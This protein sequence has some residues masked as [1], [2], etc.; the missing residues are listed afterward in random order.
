MKVENT[1]II[2]YKDRLID[3]LGADEFDNF[4]KNN[5]KKLHNLTYRYKILD[6]PELLEKYRD[7]YTS[8]EFRVR[9]NNLRK[10]KKL[11]ENNENNAL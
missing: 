8:Y 2:Q 4:F 7:K 3:E 11:L 10:L 1:L 9:Q 5:R 6:N